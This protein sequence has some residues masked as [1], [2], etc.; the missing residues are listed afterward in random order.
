MDVDILN[1]Y[2]NEA[3]LSDLAEKGDL[4][5]FTVTEINRSTCLYAKRVLRVDGTFGTNGVYK[6][7]EAQAAKRICLLSRR[8]G[9]ERGEYRWSATW[10]KETFKAEVVHVKR[11]LA[12]F[13]VAQIKKFEMSFR[14]KDREKGESGPFDD[15]NQT[16][17][18][19]MSNLFL[20]KQGV[21]S[22]VKD[23]F[24]YDYQACNG[25]Y[26][27]KGD[28]TAKDFIENRY[29]EHWRKQ[30]YAVIK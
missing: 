27:L 2:K 22:E 26:Y 24:K 11:L 1:R 5:Y 4:V 29:V 3:V 16:Y 6:W 10:Y 13:G 20:Q 21:L 12:G 15:K 25:W 14:L 30:K 8:H 9:N 7:C 18:K 23:S 17:I 19:E 28:P